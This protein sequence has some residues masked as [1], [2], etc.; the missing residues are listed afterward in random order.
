MSES[1]ADL[2]GE[3]RAAMA[4]LF[5]MSGPA[6]RRSLYRCT[7]LRVL[8]ER[9]GMGQPRAKRH[10][11]EAAVRAV[12][13]V[14]DGEADADAGRAVLDAIAAVEQGQAAG[15]ARDAIH[16][17]LREI[18]P[19]FDGIDAGAKGGGSDDS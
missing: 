3:L 14:S 1:R 6:P 15:G 16:Y 8:H 13:E 19:A 9:L 17:A 2:T 12:Q 5:G 7:A 18:L 11:L 10:A 4:G